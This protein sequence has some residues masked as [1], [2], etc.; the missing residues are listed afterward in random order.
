LGVLLAPSVVLPV[1]VPTIYIGKPDHFGLQVGWPILA[2]VGL[3]LCLLRGPLAAHHGRRALLTRFLLLFGL[4]FVMTWTPWD[5]WPALPTLYSYVQFSYRLLMFVVL[6]GALLS[7]YALAL[8]FKGRMQAVHVAAIVLGLGLTAG[9]YLSPQEVDPLGGLSKEV[10][11]PNMGRGGANSVYAIA[12]AHLVETSLV[13]PEMD[14]AKASTGGLLDH[15]EYHFHGRARAVFNAP[16]EGDALRLEGTITDDAPAPFQITITVDERTIATPTLPRGPFELTIPLEP[17]P[18]KE[19]V[20][21][22]VECKPV[23][24]PAPPPRFRPFL[25]PSCIVK[26]LALEAGPAYRPFPRFL[27][28]EEVRPKM[29]FGHPTTLRLHCDEATLVQLP[30]V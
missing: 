20:T 11:N 8:G 26:S 29:E 22:I 17:V 12:A 9:G 28:S 13:H 16:R 1:H 19:Q 14:W 15:M 3:S 27:T 18:G 5:F 10:A 21:V 7:A 24:M 25:H 23:R 30:V 4:A 6:W 2:A